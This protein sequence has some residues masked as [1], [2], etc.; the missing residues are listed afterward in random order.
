MLYLF[1]TTNYMSPSCSLFQD[2]QVILWH[3]WE[4]KLIS[5]VCHTKVNPSNKLP[6]GNI[7]VQVKQYQISIYPIVQ[8]SEQLL[9]LNVTLSH[10]LS[11]IA[12]DQFIELDSQ[13]IYIATHAIGTVCVS[14]FYRPE[15]FLA[16]AIKINAALHNGPPI[17]ASCKICWMT[18]HLLTSAFDWLRC[19]ADQAIFWMWSSWYPECSHKLN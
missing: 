10:V 16:I 1:S 7:N 9:H 8:L 2:N 15:S 18:C 12:E 3:D 19:S 13:I 4:E 14:L 5:T 11:V 6:L 17:V